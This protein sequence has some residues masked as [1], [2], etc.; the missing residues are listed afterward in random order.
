LLQHRMKAYAT[1]GRKGREM[2][3]KLGLDAS[4]YDVRADAEEL[5]RLQDESRTLERRQIERAAQKAVQA[6]F[7]TNS[8][9]VY[10]KPKRRVLKESLREARLEEVRKRQGDGAVQKSLEKRRKREKSKD[11]HN[12]KI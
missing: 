1:P 2:R 5:R 9:S 3:K 11:A 10:Y 12:M 7:K 4:N 8:T 6:K